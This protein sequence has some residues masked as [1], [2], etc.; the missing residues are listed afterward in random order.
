MH[1]YKKSFS[2]KID[3]FLTITFLSGAALFYIYKMIQFGG[4]IKYINF[5]INHAK[6]PLPIIRMFTITILVIFVS[7]FFVLSVVLSF[8]YDSARKKIE[9]KNLEKR[10]RKRIAAL[11]ENNIPITHKNMYDKNIRPDVPLDDS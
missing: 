6:N 4:P 3:N 11:K 5:I 1:K 9:K 2:K 8:Y 7:T 10:L